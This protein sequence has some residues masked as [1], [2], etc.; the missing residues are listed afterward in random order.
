MDRIVYF[1]YR[2]AC[3]AIALLPLGVCFRGGATIGWIAYWVLWPYRRLATRNLTIA[4]G[5]QKSPAELRRMAR[6]HFTRLGANLV[7]SVKFASMP[8]KEILKHV[9]VENLEALKAAVANGK[10]VVFTIS[11]LGNWEVL[12]QVSPLV[13]PCKTGTIYQRLGN[14]YIDA[15]VR[16]ARAR[17]GLQPFERKEGFLGAIALARK[18]GAV[19]VLVDQHAGDAGT[20]LPFFGR[21]ASTS[22]LAATLALRSGATVFPLAVHTVGPGRWRMVIDP[23][24]PVSTRDVSLLT[25]QINLALEQQIRR[26]PEDWFWVHNRWKTPKPNFLL[27]SYKRGIFLPEGF[28]TTQLKP[29]R[30]L[31]RSSNWLGDAVM[32]TP[33]VQAIKRGRPDVHLTVLTRSKLAEFW[34]R[35]PEVDEIISIE[36]K[37]SVSDVAQ[38]LRTKFDV[39]IVLPNSIRSAL[40]VWLAGIPRRVGYPARWRRLLLNQPVLPPKKHDLC[41]PAQHQV[42]HYLALARSLGADIPVVELPDRVE[43]F[44]KS[45][46]AANAAIGGTIKIGLCP[47][48]E[49][50]PAKRWLPERFAEVART[51]SEKI[52]CEWVLFGVAGDAPVG[53]AIEG[54]LNPQAEVASGDGTQSPGSET[55]QSAHAASTV[56]CTNLIGKTTLSELMDRLSECRLLLTNDTG[57][58]HLAAFLGV[59]TVSIF[60]STEPRLTA[61]LGPGH[62]VLR[63][64]VECSPCFLRE[65][66][67]DFR[68]MKAVT[69][70]ETVAAVQRVLI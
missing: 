16:I 48:A 51:I 27:S 5:D 57:T 19:G 11:H 63:H 32:S 37:D 1:F 21:L 45:A 56:K 33:A 58:M 10:G 8:G 55:V 59:P 34:K 44:Q 47:G 12:A 62:Q 67:L 40:E 38:K 17:L 68:C 13:F 3:K 20:W 69:V 6:A 64:Q 14:P 22:P 50:G 36:V 31:V 66:P 54:L 29:F 41:K 49:Y 60:G 2:I 4:F 43:F 53:A 39:A 42:Q 25:M 26:A 15:D 30:I 7:S 24:L 61:P 46:R 35:V 9:A 18:G 23:P 65:C 70:E 28:D 52:D